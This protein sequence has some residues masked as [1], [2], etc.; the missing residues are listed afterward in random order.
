MDLIEQ[1]GEKEID[2]NSNVLFAMPS[3]EIFYIADAI[4]ARQ[5]ERLKEFVEWCLKNYDEQ[6]VVWEKVLKEVEYKDL[7]EQMLNDTRN[8]R[9]KLIAYY[10]CFLEETSNDN[11]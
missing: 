3:T 7:A 6:I 2:K 9:S 1:K 10:Q 8:E 4:I 5:D 11:K